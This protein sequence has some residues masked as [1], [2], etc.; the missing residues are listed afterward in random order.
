MIVFLYEIIMYI[1]MVII[2]RYYMVV[3]VYEHIYSFFSFF[4][5]MWVK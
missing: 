3:Y 2:N 4:L 5:M 1:I